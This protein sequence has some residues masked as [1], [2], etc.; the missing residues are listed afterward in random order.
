MLPAKELDGKKGIEKM[1]NTKQRGLGSLFILISAVCFSFAGVLIK[2]ISWSSLS[3]NGIRNI[4]AFGVM[5][6]FLQKKHHKLVLNKVVLLGAGC[7]LLMNL[8]F[9]MATKLTSAANAIVLQFIEPIFLILF[10]WMFW[11]QK[12]DRKAVIACLLV[13]SGI[14]CFFFDKLSFKGQFGNLLAIFSGALYAFVFLIKKMKNSDFE[15]SILISQLASF[16][17]FLPSYFKETD[18]SPKNLLLILLLGVV[19]MGLGYV[20]LSIGLNRV[21]PI[22]ASLT[23]MIEPILNPILVALFYGEMISPLAFVGAV[24]VLISSTG[25]NILNSAEE[26]AE[27]NHGKLK[28]NVEV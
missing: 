25:Y 18:F 15:S 11:K 26:N 28:E 1:I 21:S 13:F 14:L 4:L 24:I 6:L 17:I 20:F 10:L 3:I 22:A 19:Q 23:S 9:V 27:C 5:L 2:M 12:P 16:V 8:A 7:N